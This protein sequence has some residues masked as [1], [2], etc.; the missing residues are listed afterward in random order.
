[1]TPLISVGRGPPARKPVMTIDELLSN[2]HRD[3]ADR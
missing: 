1:M 3:R 2:L